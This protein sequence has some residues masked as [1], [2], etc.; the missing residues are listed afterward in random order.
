MPTSP[1][2]TIDTEN[3]DF[4][5]ANNLLQFTNHS[6]FLTGRAGTGKSTF[7]RHISKETSKCH[8]VVAPT[9]IAAI[10]VRGVT[11]HSFFQLPLG[12]ILPNDERLK[13]LKYSKEKI[14]L[15]EK[16]EL[17]IIDEISMVRADLMDA[18]DRAL[19]VVRKRPLPFGGVQLLLVGDLFQLE[20][21][22]KKEEWAWLE[23]YYSTPFFF[24]A[25]VFHELDLINIELT[26]IYRQSDPYF[27]GL[28][29]QVRNGVA[30]YN[31]IVA[32]NQRPGRPFFN[33]KQ[34]YI[35]L[36]AT[37]NIA[38]N[39]NHEKLQQLKGPEFLLKGE[40][41]D[42]F[43]NKNLPTEKELT[44]KERAQVIFIK[45]DFGEDSRRWVNGTLGVIE[46]VEDDGVF[47][48][49]EDGET[50]KVKKVQWDNIQYEY[51]AGKNR[52]VDK[53]VGTFTQFPLKLA[54]A[55]TIHKSQ[56]L[57]FER[58]VINLGRGAFAAGQLY[59][60]LSRCTTL[61][62][63]VLK[64][65]IRSSDV[66]VRRAVLEFYQKMNDAAQIKKA[67]EGKK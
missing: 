20:P 19:R 58:V 39:T 50:H 26:T 51:D 29:N 46:K 14:N 16:L 47:V 64:T 17:L 1:Q 42:N 44:L 48:K 28:L 10:N 61:E 56:G 32:L 38:D 7:L 2:A 35:T 11:I 41:E 4:Q 66:I 31:D 67:L 62:G 36:C 18:I 43:P 34:F 23:N 24:D 63:I 15:I 3:P 8:V 59:V 30:G 13:S 53:V 57:T 33:E 25:Q 52:I 27:I 37:R 45:N 9:G 12:P 22:T 5:N 21:V 60:A 55:I 40:I 65:R 6:I 49:L 54:W